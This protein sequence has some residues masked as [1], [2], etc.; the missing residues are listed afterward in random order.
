MTKSKTFLLVITICFFAGCASQ[1]VRTPVT[2]TDPNIDECF[3]LVEAGKYQEAIPVCELAAENNPDSLIAHSSLAGALAETGQIDLAEAEYRKAVAIDPQSI[4]LRMRLG[5]MLLDNNDLQGASQEFTEVQA[6]Q[7]D[8]LDAYTGLARTYVRMNNIDGAV[9]NFQRAIELQSDNESLYLELSGFLDKAGRRKQARQVLKDASLNGSIDLKYA[10]ASIL[11]LHKRYTQA[12]RQ[13]GKVVALNKMYKNALFNQAVCYY[14]AGD[15]QN[16][17]KKLLVFVR[18]NPKS[19]A[20]QML[21]GQL[22]YDRGNYTGAEKAYKRAIGL[23]N[24]NGPAWV[25]LGNTLRQRGDKEG[26]KK[27]Y[28]QALRINPKDKTAKKN[29]KRLY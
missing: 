4:L 9:E 19:S 11:H 16:A 27:A 18:N 17:E 10:Y 2:D 3:M 28:R 24:S 29:L 7:A 22:S 21:L 23:D 15:T 1:P 8:Y 13:Y 5:N 14:R 12:A 6:I 26:A 25:L 20:G